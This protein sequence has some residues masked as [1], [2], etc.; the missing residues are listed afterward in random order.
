MI[1]K[2]KIT[3]AELGTII[4]SRCETCK[5]VI[6]KCDMCGKGFFRSPL[7]GLYHSECGLHYCGICA[8]DMEI[9]NKIERKSNPSDK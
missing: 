2:Y 8:E 1:S 4:K 9:V 6:G 7:R 5:K 3:K